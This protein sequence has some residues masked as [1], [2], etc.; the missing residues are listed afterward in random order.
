MAERRRWTILVVGTLA[1][2][3]TCSFLYG[4]P[5]LVPALRAEGLSLFEASLLVSAP[6]VGLLLTLI[7]W[8]AAADRY[9]E[10][11]VIVT[12]VGAS[13]VLLACA[14]VVP[15]SAGLAVLLAL[16]GAFGASV[17]AAS[18]RVVMGWFPVAER[19]LAMGTRQTAQPLGVAIAAL[20][21]PT[22]GR[23]HG[24][25]LALLFPALVCALTAAATALLVAD[26]PRPAPVEGV[27]PVRSPYRGSTH[28]PRVHVSSALL[29][30]PQFAVASFTLIFL[31]HERHWD[32]A[33]AGRLVFAFQVAGAAGRIA[34]GVWSDRVGSRLRP[35][36]QLAVTSAALMVVIALGAWSG[37]W[38]VVAG[39]ALGAVVTVADNG[40]AYTAV[41]EFAGR[42]WSGRALGVQNTVQNVA[43]IA[44]A[45]VLAAVI[46]D[47]RYAVGF[48]LVAVFP[49]LAIPLTPVRA[50]RRAADE[51]ARN[52][53]RAARS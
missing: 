47:S 31:V 11:V 39:F 20:A 49:L 51:Q 50:E 10:H 37:L 21:L 33:A 43:A 9:G 19:G 8:G 29:V 45:P 40:L 48:A 16:A 3:A 32:A 7:A 1:Q 24:A 30:V 5:M 27:P 28:L 36:R 12:G 34:S 26:P 52:A 35:M 44:T 53:E 22:L 38:F 2:A 4:I 14:A 15:G 18:G 6:M 23:E 25:H 46:G 42:E 17:N 41:A 13:A